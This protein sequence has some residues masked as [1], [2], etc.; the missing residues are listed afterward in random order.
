MHFY[1]EITC[2]SLVVSSRPNVDSWIAVVV[3][4]SGVEVRPHSHKSSH[5]PVSFTLNSL[6]QLVF[7]E[8]A[9]QLRV[10]LPWQSS[11]CQTCRLQVLWSL[12]CTCLQTHRS[13]GSVS[14]ASLARVLML[15]WTDIECMCPT[16]SR[17]CF[18]PQMLVKWSIISGKSFLWEVAY[19]Q[20]H[21]VFYLPN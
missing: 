6:Q 15:V 17:N 13:Y 12:C 10:C 5:C 14:H 8:Q 16:R 11:V 1:L 9:W 18:W 2:I 19:S 4:E 7:V 3:R 21:H 20:W